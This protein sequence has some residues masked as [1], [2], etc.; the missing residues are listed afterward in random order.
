MTSFPL[1][2]IPSNP[3]SQNPYFDLC[4]SLS[5]HYRMLKITL[6]CCCCNFPVYSRHIIVNKHN[7][8]SIMI[9]IF[10]CFTRLFVVQKDF[11]FDVKPIIQTEKRRCVLRDRGVFTHP[12]TPFLPQGHCMERIVNRFLD[13]GFLL[14]RARDS[15]FQGKNVVRFGIGSLRGRQDGKSNP[16]D[17]GIELNFGSG[18]RD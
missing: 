3:F 18:L 8:D 6:N 2:N 1:V 17:Y 13:P 7:A 12:S 5:G 14:F 9:S 16:R 10:Q 4:T 15:E 11:T